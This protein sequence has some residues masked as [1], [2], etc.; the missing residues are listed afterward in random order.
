MTSLFRVLHL[1]SREENAVQ[2]H[3][4]MARDSE[5]E[6][7]GSDKAGF[8]AMGIIALISWISSFG[9][10]SFLTYRFLF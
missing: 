5:V 10:L 8:I 4:L 1:I 7:L 9:L 2:P 3:Q 6:L